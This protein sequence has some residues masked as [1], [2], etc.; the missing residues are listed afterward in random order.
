MARVFGCLIG[1]YPF[2]YP[3]LPEGTK[4][5]FENHAPRGN[6]FERRISATSTWFT[7]AVKSTVVEI[8]VSVFSAPEKTGWSRSLVP[9]LR[10]FCELQN[11]L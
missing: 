7:M 4:S 11:T 8:V 6:N 1:S 3:G 5:K 2:T 10:W 9:V